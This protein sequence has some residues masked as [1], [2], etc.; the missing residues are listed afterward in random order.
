MQNQFVEENSIQI[1]ICER[2][3]AYLKNNALNKRRSSKFYKLLDELFGDLLLDQEVIK[4]ISNKVN[5]PCCYLKENFLERQ[6]IFGLP[7]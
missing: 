3:F 7:L 2:I 5:I 6:R 1:Q 4:Y